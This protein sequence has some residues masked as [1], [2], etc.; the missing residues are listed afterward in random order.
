MCLIT[1]SFEGCPNVLFESL[2]CGNFNIININ[3]NTDNFIVDGYS[4]L[5]YDGSDNDLIKKINYFKQLYINK[6]HYYMINNGLNYCRSNFSIKKMVYKYENLYQ[7]IINKFH[8]EK[9]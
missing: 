4:G 5:V 7:H 6:E 1:S 3:A 9:N 8:Y 2:L